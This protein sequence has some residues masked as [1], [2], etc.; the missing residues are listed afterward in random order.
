MF[1]F[2]LL[3]L[4]VLHEYF[5][6]LCREARQSMTSDERSAHRAERTYIAEL[7]AR[8]QLEVQS[9]V[10]ETGAEAGPN[11]R[12]AAPVNPTSPSSAWKAVGNSWQ[13]NAE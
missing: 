6:V 9:P 1:R 7:L 3:P 8:D 13:I 12:A 2:E 5:G 11:R 4:E 10:P